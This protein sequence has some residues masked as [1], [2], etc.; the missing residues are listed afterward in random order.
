M[1]KY[2]KYTHILIIWHKYTLGKDSHHLVNH[3]VLRMLE[4]SGR[5]GSC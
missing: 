2:W 1:E 5:S 4:K 3:V